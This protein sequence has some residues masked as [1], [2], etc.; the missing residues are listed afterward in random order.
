MRA[1]WRLRREAARLAST[2]ELFFS[3]DFVGRKYETWQTHL[4]EFVARPG[5]RM[6]EIGCLEGK[7]ALWFLEH[8]LT[9][10]GSRLTCV[11]PWHPI[12][13]LRFDHNIRIAGVSNRIRVIRKPS[14]EALTEELA[15]ERF[16]IIYIDGNHTAPHVLFDALFAW[17]LLADGGTLIFDDYEWKPDFPLGKRPKP[18]IDRFLSLHEDEMEVLRVAYQV[19]VRKKGGIF[20]IPNTRAT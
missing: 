15:D 19:I 13:K 2:D 4:A 5:V 10:P 8:V 6:L 7:S 16:H 1:R 14:E 11:D 20:R 18:S 3:R 17:P 12:I 9:G